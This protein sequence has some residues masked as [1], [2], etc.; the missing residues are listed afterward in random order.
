MFEGKKRRVAYEISIPAQ[1]D[2]SA[3]N[4]AKRQFGWIWIA[5]IFTARTWRIDQN[6]DSGECQTSW[7]NEVHDMRSII[8]K[9]LFVKLPAVKGKHE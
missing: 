9:A 1:V 6:L 8:W 5:D 2:F 7:A 4:L 3:N